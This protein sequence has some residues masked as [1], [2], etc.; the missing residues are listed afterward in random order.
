MTFD[1]FSA[2]RPR[3]DVL[4]HELSDAV[5]AASLDEVV[6][7]TAPD[8][9]RDAELFFDSTW[10][11]QGLRDLLNEVFGRLTGRRPGA[12][13]VIR[14][15][16]NLGGGKTHNLIALWHTAHGRLDPMRAMAFM[17]PDLL[18]DG[19]VRVASLVGTGAGASS[20][21]AVDGVEART[22]WEYLGLQL[23][24]PEAARLLTEGDG[25]TAPGASRIKEVLGDE[26]TLILL[27]ELARYLETAAGHGVG[28][29]NLARQTVAFL[30]ALMEAVDARPRASLVI[31]TTEVTDAFGDKT[32]QLLDAMSEARGLMA[33]REHVLRPSAEADLPK[34]L[35]RRL[36]ERVDDAG[37]EVGRRYAE[38]A[39]DVYSRGGDLSP[40]AVSNTWADEVAAAWPFHPWLV[41]LLDKRLSTIPNFQRTRGALRL[42]ASTIRNLW[43][44]RPPGTLAIHPFHLDLADPRILEDL[45]SRLGRGEMENAVRAD[46]ASQEGG[47]PSRAEL[48]DAELGAP[49]ARRLATT[50][51]VGSLTND[52]PGL[53]AQDLVT[54][55]L[56]PGDDVNVMA[57]ALE[58][59]EQRCWYLHVD[60]RGYRFSTEKSL[61][62]VIQDA[63]A[64]IPVGR[65]RAEA[66]AILGR[67]HRDAALKVRRAW[68]DS[69]VPD[70]EHEA[71][72][73]ILHWDDFGDARGVDPRGPVP[74]RVRELWERTPAGGLRE[75]RNRVVFLCPSA[76]ETHDAMVDAVRRHLAL[77][78]L[79]K[80]EV[81]LKDLAENKRAELKEMAAESELL[82]RIAV[83]NHV[84]VL[85]V[86]QR[87]GL[88]VEVLPTVTKASTHPNQTEAIVDHLRAIGKTRAAGD[89]PLDPAMVRS[90]L[91]AMLDAP[92]PTVEL[93]RAFARRSDLPMV[94]DPGQFVTVVRAGVVNGVWEY[95]DTTRGG[96]GWATKDRPPTTAVRVG[97][98]TLLHPVGSAPPVEVPSC[99][100]CGEVHEGPCAAQPEPTKETTTS[101]R[102][103]GAAPT[104]VA[105]VLQEVTDA[106][107]R[108]IRRFVIAVNEVG[109]G[110][111]AELARLQSVVPA[112]LDRAEVTW[113]VEVSATLDDATHHVRVTFHGP[114]ADWA[115]LKPAVDQVLATRPATLRASCAVTFEDP[116]PPDHE[117]VAELRARAGRTGPS[118]CD[119]TVEVDT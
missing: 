112:D 80:D 30:M 101:Y 61:V 106:G 59:L 116:V 89:P 31:T 87:D 48:I 10:P 22:L 54:A 78:E 119:V 13:S 38:A 70:R 19:P 26:P 56:A 35:V 25:M 111:K 57:R 63:Q 105:D 14:L 103:S 42:L 40:E 20:F 71:A 67:I 27:D 37:A 68:E 81:V 79:A 15:E 3:P 58:L 100:F 52:V 82:A 110:L 2:C 17:D 72:L 4:A 107:L 95:E 85:Y 99:P 55:A 74:D 6:N 118:R 29:S 91:G 84:N 44:Q 21:P 39:R 104:A 33:R 66:T 115:P 88:E 97:E 75:F 86:P 46:I 18:P 11:S 102:G 117:V 109:E 28:E 76:G 47:E 49:F 32:Q 43:E 9:Y 16:T 65:V 113:D 114:P 50:A 73:V 94:L 1:L 64:R 41:R 12:A 53:P 34:I 92:V 83:C 5:F 24:G 98:D 93:A 108:P 45:T 96:D 60:H 90:R 8:A 77:T 23:G 51:F 36:F 62:K 69:K 7:E